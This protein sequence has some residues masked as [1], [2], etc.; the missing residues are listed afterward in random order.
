MDIEYLM[1]NSDSI[2][3]LKEKQDGASSPSLESWYELHL[4]DLRKGQIEVGRDFLSFPT[5]ITKLLS[6][7]HVTPKS[8]GVRG[9]WR[10][11]G[12]NKTWI[13]RTK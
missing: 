11:F 4:L 7:N 9:Q 13:V 12:L 3:K 6:V 2:N 1:N 5:L 8:F 10:H